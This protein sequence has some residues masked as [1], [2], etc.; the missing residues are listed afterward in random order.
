M[1]LATALLAAISIT[2]A[3]SLSSTSQA[4]RTLRSA[5][6]EHKIAIGTA[7]HSHLLGDPAYTSVLAPQF[8]QLEPENEMKFAI[9][10]PLPKVYDFSG[11]DAMVSFARLHHML[12]RGHTLVWHTQVPLWITAG[13][14][15]SFQL[16]EI[17]QDHI[18]TVMKHYAGE[19]YAWDVVNEAF[20]EDGTMRD[21]IWYDEPGI[22][23]AYLNTKY[24]EQAFLWARAADPNAKLFYNDYD[25]EP[26]NAKSDAIYN[27]ARDFKKRGVP[28]DG[29]GF[30]LHVTLAFDHPKT[31]D[32]FAANMQRFAN[33]G[34][35]IHIT[36]LDIRLSDSKP[37]S[38]LAQGKLYS[39]ITTLC[40]QQP[41]CKALQTWGFTDAHSWIPGFFPGTGWALPWDSNY[42][43]K[44]A[45][46]GILKSLE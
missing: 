29:V 42:Q 25:A 28:L 20:N 11:A 44:P 14:D 4:Q 17:L 34:L 39:E 23:C 7:V 6:A 32:S 40:V 21:T 41:A 35:E 2:T 1:R 13:S 30:Q 36:E 15:N 33:L 37:D 46:F 10:H 26:I 24:V 16:A 3:I 18:A 31:L 38:L 22:G 9:I 8:S 19:V 5:A 27:M 43:R 45:Y 12:V